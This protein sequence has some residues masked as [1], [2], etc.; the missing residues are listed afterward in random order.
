MKMKWDFRKQEKTIPQG[1]WQVKMEQGKR[2]LAGWLQRQSERW[3]IRTKKVMLILCSL[4]FGSAMLWQVFR[5]IGSTRLPPIGMIAKPI[6]PLPL[7]KMETDSIQ[8]DR[9]NTDNKSDNH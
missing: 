4:L 9:G 7:Q 5:G 2:R 8:A 1:K 3:S 6:T